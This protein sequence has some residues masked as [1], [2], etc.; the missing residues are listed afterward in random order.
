MIK[1]LITVGLGG[2]VGSIIRFL[3]SKYIQNY[4]NLV[5]PLGTFVVNILG[6]FLIGLLF[7]LS[8]KTNLINDEVR[9]FLTV[10]FC[11]GFTT[12]SSFAHENLVLLREGH[13]L[14]LSLYIGLS[15]LLGIFAVYLGTLT[16]KIMN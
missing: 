1:S 3:V 4:F 16:I 8:F 7:G 15:V 10:G 2:F 9:L 5:F 12:F 13:I 14:Q 11:G 6:C